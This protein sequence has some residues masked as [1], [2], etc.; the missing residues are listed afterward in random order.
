MEQI[1]LPFQPKQEVGMRFFS[2]RGVVDRVVVYS[3]AD[4][5]I[6]VKGMDG[7]LIGSFDP[8]DLYSLE[9]ELENCRT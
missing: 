8:C 3:P 2:S 5:S 7:K 1:R 6:F 9:D 4:M